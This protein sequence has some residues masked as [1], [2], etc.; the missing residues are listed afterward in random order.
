[1]NFYLFS[2]DRV[3]IFPLLVKILVAFYNIY[4]GA[5]LMNNSLVGDWLPLTKTDMLFLSL[6]NS[7][8]V[9]LLYC[10]KMQSLY[11]SAPVPKLEVV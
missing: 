5:P 3:T 9:I 4:S 8:W 2:G 1:M 7:N 11:L 10:Y 6:V